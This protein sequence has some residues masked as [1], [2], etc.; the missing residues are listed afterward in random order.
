[1][2]RSSH[3]KSVNREGDGGLYDHYFSR[4]EAILRVSSIKVQIFN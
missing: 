1:M 4:S 3:D 2:V